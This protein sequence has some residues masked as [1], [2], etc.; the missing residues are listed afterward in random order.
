MEKKKNFQIIVLIITIYL[1]QNR[2]IYF[3]KS[4]FLYR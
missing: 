3:L 1:Q 2:Y 4:Y